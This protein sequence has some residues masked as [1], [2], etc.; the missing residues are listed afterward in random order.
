MVDA[1]GFWDEIAVAE[2]L[3]NEMVRVGLGSAEHAFILSFLDGAFDRFA[4]GLS[5]EFG[6]ARDNIFELIISAGGMR[7]NIAGVGELVT[8]APK[9][10][11]WRIIAFK[12]RQDLSVPIHL[13]GHVCEQARTRVYWQERDG[14]FDTLVFVDVPSTAEKNTVTHA[15]FLAL[16]N[17]LG[18]FDVMQHL[19]SID[20]RRLD[21]DPRSQNLPTI[22]EFVAA[23]DKRFAGKPQ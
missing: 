9:F 15:G 7:D 13:N 11:K 12:P 18:E 6:A 23:F 14:R 2:N 10:E 21:D 22:S 5:F 17:A 19:R 4:P 16:D 20:I 8:S 3:I 1:K